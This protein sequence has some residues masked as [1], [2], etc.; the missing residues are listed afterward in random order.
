[1]VFLSRFRII[2]H[3]ASRDQFEMAGLSYYALHTEQE[4]G[5]ISTRLSMNMKHLDKH[6]KGLH[7]HILVSIDP[8]SK[9]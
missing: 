8:L 5:V 9:C 1:M 7:G 4:T 2:R 6:L 3:K